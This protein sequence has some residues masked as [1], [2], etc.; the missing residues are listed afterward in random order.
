L[1]FFRKK[2]FTTKTKFFRQTKIKGERQIAILYPL[3][4]DANA[5]M[6]FN[7]LAKTCVLTAKDPRLVPTCMRL[8]VLLPRILGVGSKLGLRRT[9]MHY[10]I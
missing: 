10:S 6:H 3:C 8:S 7:A 1:C 5:L 2:N 4:R 9:G